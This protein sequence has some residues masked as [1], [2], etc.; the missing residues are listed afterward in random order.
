M[1]PS[2]TIAFLFAANIIR[3]DKNHLAIIPIPKSVPRF[4]IQVPAEGE[5][6]VYP[7]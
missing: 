7:L 1:L 6:S 4:F 5:E 2:R 3:S